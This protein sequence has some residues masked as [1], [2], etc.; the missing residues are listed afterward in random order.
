MPKS[1]VER[2]IRDSRELT[3]YIQRLKKEGNQ[4]RAYTMIKKRE[5]IEKQLT[6]I[7]EYFHYGD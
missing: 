3:H 4:Q 2:L 6:D 1:Q 7:E 5:F